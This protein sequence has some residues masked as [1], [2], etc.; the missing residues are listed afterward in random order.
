MI[1]SI[2]V[3]F[4]IVCLIF[5]QSFASGLS[6]S[7]PMI[8]FVFLSMTEARKINLFSFSKRK[9]RSLDIRVSPEF[10]AINTARSLI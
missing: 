5:H 10:Q 7:S 8:A 9:K 2:L 1:Q 6:S 4:V 3:I